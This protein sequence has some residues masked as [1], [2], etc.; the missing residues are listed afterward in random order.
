MGEGRE[1]EGECRGAEVVHEHV[2]RGGWG[3]RGSWEGGQSESKKTRESRGSKQPLLYW[4][5]HRELLPCKVTAGRSLENANRQGNLWRELAAL[6][7][8]YQQAL[9]SADRLH[10]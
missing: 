9:G 10:W 6:D 2:E 4:V 8:A 7:K 1:G 3:E 5:R